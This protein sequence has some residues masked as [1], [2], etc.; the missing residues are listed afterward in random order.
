M[1]T[2]KRIFFLSFAW[3]SAAA[4]ALSLSDFTAVHTAR[5]THEGPNRVRLELPSAE[6]DCQMNM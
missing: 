3:S 1:N 6:W 2:L 4:S 5:V